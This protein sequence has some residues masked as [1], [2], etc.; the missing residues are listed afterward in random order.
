MVGFFRRRVEW[1]W[2]EV[3]MTGR[4]R[5]ECDFNKWAQREWEERGD[6]VGFERE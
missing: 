5:E 6:P 3:D 2:R 1:I 4:A